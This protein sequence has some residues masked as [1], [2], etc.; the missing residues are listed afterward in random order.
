[1]EGGM[2]RLKKWMVGN[3]GRKHRNAMTLRRT[4]QEAFFLLD[5]VETHLKNSGKK[6][7]PAFDLPVESA[8]AI[9][10]L[11]RKQSQ[12]WVRKQ[13]TSAKDL[14]VFRTAKRRIRRVQYKDKLQVFKKDTVTVMR[15]AVPSVYGQGFLKK[16][17]AVHPYRP[18]DTFMAWH[19]VNVYKRETRFD[20]ID[21]LCNIPILA[22]LSLQGLKKVV[23]W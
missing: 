12:L 17:V 10:K 20:V 11:L 23:Q 21:A 1:M 4:R 2:R 6:D 3:D 18:M 14:Q 16:P 13:K 7:C 8:A 22:G 5:R 19:R 9:H 15:A